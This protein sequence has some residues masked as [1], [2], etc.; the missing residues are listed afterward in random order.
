[1][2]DLNAANSSAGTAGGGGGGHRGGEHQQGTDRTTATRVSSSAAVTRLT[3]SFPPRAV[4]SFFCYL[5][6]SRVGAAAAI[7]AKMS[8]SAR[9]SPTTLF[10]SSQTPD[11]CLC[12]A[13]MTPPKF[14]SPACTLNSCATRHLSHAVGGVAAA[15]FAL[16][17]TTTGTLMVCLWSYGRF[18]SIRRR[19]WDSH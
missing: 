3:P 12:D 16:T 11:A 1:M 9:L 8:A 17:M 4:S 2:Q 7:T 15:T 13:I 14:Q 6:W 19:T 10:S 5:V 18:L